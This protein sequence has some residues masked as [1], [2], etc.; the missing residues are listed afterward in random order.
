[1]NNPVG[2]GNFRKDPQRNGLANFL[3]ISLIEFFVFPFSENIA[4]FRHNFINIAQ[5]IAN[6]AEHIKTRN[7]KKSEQRKN[8][9]LMTFCGLSGAKVFKSY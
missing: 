9:F 4:K 6:I 1:M 3:Q 7:C 5:K 2:F 8:I